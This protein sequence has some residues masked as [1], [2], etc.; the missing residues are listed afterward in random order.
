[1]NIKYILKTSSKNKHE[2]LDEGKSPQN[3]LK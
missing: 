1:M 2:K 3:E